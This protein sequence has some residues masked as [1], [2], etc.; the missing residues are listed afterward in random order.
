MPS[1]HKGVMLSPKSGRVTYTPATKW[2][3]Y[4][5]NM[6][7][8]GQVPIQ[9]STLHPGATIFQNEDVDKAMFE[10]VTPKNAPAM[11][12]KGKCVASFYCDQD[13]KGGMPTRVWHTLVSYPIYNKTALL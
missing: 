7:G 6:A 11:E 12:Y 4:I 8:V 5:Q 1:I 3:G 2:P 10:G 13:P 9:K